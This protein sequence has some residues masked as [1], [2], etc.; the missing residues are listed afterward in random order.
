MTIEL[1]RYRRAIGGAAPPAAP[2]VAGGAADPMGEFGVALAGLGER[3]AAI[4]AARTRARHQTQEM[5]ARGRADL[6]LA[7]LA[8]AEERA[9]DF[10][11][12][13]ARF[14]AQAN[15]VRDDLA[16]GIEDEDRR[17]AFVLDTD[18]AIALKRIRL[19][20]GAFKR[21]IDAG[22]AVV[23]E[24]QRQT[25]RAA[26][27]AASPAERQEVLAGFV[28][29][30]GH[31][32]RAQLISAQERVAREAALFSEV[33][34]LDAL[35]LIGGDDAALAQAAGLLGRP[36]AFP[37]LD[38]LKKERLHRQA[39]AEQGR[40]GR[41]AEAGQAVARAAL[42]DRTRDHLASLRETGQ[43]VD[44][45]S[46]EAVAG[47]LGET[48]ARRFAADEDLARRT[49]DTVSA[50]RWAAP[51][52]AV[53]ALDALKPA[54][55]TEG[56]AEASAAHGQAVGAYR[57]LHKAFEQ[58]PAGYVAAMPGVVDIATS[59]AAQRRLGV[60]P[61]AEWTL[62]KAEAEG[63]VARLLAAKGEAKADAIQALAEAHSA[64]WPLVHRDLV[65]AGLPE[66]YQILATTDHP[67]AR[68]ALAEALATPKGDLEKAAGAEA[69]AVRETVAA[70]LEEML[71]SFGLAPNGVAIGQRYQDAAT[72]L[73]WR[74][75][76]AGAEAEDAARRAAGELL[77]DKYDLVP[78]EGGV[79]ARAPKGRGGEA[80]AYADHLLRGLRPE[81]LADI[82]GGAGLTPENRRESARAAARRGVWVTNAA[83]DG[84]LL[85]DEIRQ[86][87]LRADGSPVAFRFAD[88]DAAPPAERGLS[89]ETNPALR[90]AEEIR[91]WQ[92]RRWADELRLIEGEP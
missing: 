25:A 44:G 73:A 13:P 87:V 27:E 10:A 90:R 36:K 84:W 54:P 72:R 91:M 21:E 61:G 7:E 76:A 32:E 19:D 31:A 71:R 28:A 45:V 58:D 5:E 16:G 38:P 1:P 4:G 12:A 39:V 26:A 17:R 24:R 68:R 29:E 67:V 53:A 42:A 2:R 59:H 79:V 35:R 52:E 88:L 20:G 23:A 47:L 9:A 11:G 83:D 78:Q 77:L 37:H 62:P 49:H 41:E 82:G 74:Y 34:E 8:A 22:R 57:R 40:R 18:R 89:V 14:V 33:E 15:R 69:Q 65:R 55:G 46:V 48:A 66:D 92:K 50:L 75:V 86:P 63:R 85:L 30:L 43:G 70:E 80:A 56:Y 3:M 64:D 51:A 60:A 81:E 6:S